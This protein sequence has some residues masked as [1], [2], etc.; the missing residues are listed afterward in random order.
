MRD[1]KIIVARIVRGSDSGCDQ[2][3][4][5]L[6]VLDLLAGDIVGLDGGNHAGSFLGGLF[7]A[8]PELYGNVG[9]LAETGVDNQQRFPNPVFHAGH[10]AA[11]LR[12]ARGQLVSGF[13]NRLLAAFRVACEVHGLLRQRF[14]K[15]R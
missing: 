8:P 13:R 10:F 15:R 4:R 6:H 9:L 3:K 1:S 5:L 2:L 11:Q 14:R 7:R 12:Q